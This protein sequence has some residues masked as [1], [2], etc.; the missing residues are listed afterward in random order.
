MS[1]T[2]LNN[3]EHP[4]LSSTF[5][6]RLF[7]I[8]LRALIISLLILIFQ[9]IAA[10]ENSE[11]QDLH[12]LLSLLDSQTE[13]AT[14]SRM[15]A[16]YV[17]GMASILYGDDL[18]ARGARTAWEALG[19]V[20]GISL[21]MEFTGERQ[22]LSRGVG[23]GYA[24]G[25]VKILVDGISLNSTLLGTANPALNMPIEQIEQIEV[26]RGAGASVYGEYA[27]AGVV[28][29]ITKQTTNRLNS[30]YE[31]DSHYGLGGIWHLLDKENELSLSLN[32]SGLKGDG[33]DVDVEEDAW[34]HTGQS[35]L[36]NAPGTSNEARQYL[37]LFFDLEWKGLFASVKLL[38]DAYGD[39]FGIN[40]FLPP[41]DNRLASRQKYRS[42]SVGSK[43][44]LSNTLNAE[45]RFELLE[46]E[47]NRDQLYIYP[48]DFISSYP[49]Y[50]DSYYTE[51]KYLIST[52]FFWRPNLKHDA[53]LSVKGSDTSIQDAGWKW[54][55]L[56]FELPSNWIDT[57]TNRNIFTLIIQDQYRFSEQLTLTGT[58]RYDDYSDLDSPISPRLASV[59]RLSP[60]KILKFQFSRSFRPPT[61]YE[62][63]NPG[64]GHLE[65]SAINSTEIGYIIKKSSWR[66]SFIL[67]HSD[68]RNPILFDELNYAGYINGEDAR[69][70][71]LEFEYQHRLSNNVKLDGNL[72]YVD[73]H[74]KES[75]EH[76]PGGA[77]WLANLGLIWKPLQDLSTAIQISYV[78]ERHRSNLDSR[79][80]LPATTVIDFTVGHHDLIP[81]LQFHAGVKNLAD[82]DVRYPQLL[83]TD[84]AGEA[85]L[86]YP[87]DYPRPG[88]RWW[89]SLN[90]D[91]Q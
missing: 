78:G 25:N 31:H 5:L 69:L 19:L 58:L 77:K 35:E 44:K 41:S 24:S 11:N 14:K 81:G 1:F 28:N 59:W 16:D 90:Y 18:L 71:G 54:P 57:Q 34:Y 4:Y 22:I 40:H 70:Q 7:D 48:A 85:F 56:P 82:E 27:Y 17:P 20:P 23:H 88:R 61:F 66:G 52:D 29:I 80:N 47:R 89:L 83:T 46:H 15:N 42:F 74:F 73:A 60:D 26:V 63:Q 36:S 55:E 2:N 87:N 37:G 21:G 51:R 30:H 10:A 65:L 53:L 33:H 79:N 38:D 76:L 50:L 39:H 32:I 3:T 84:F 13:L 67:F 49:I 68:L 62:L 9:E 45:V 8:S 72:S 75:G 86:P 64:Q 12:D 91:F 6:S 43:N